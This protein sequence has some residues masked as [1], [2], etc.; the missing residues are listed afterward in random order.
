MDTRLLG[1][2][3][4][5]DNLVSDD[6]NIHLKEIQN[7]IRSFQLMKSMTIKNSKMNYKIGDDVDRRNSLVSFSHDSKYLAMCCEEDSVALWDFSLVEN[8]L[9]ILGNHDSEVSA[10]AFGENYILVSGCQN[11]IVKIWND[12]R[13][14]ED[15]CEIEAHNEEITCIAVNPKGENFVTG[16]RDMTAKIWSLEDCKEEAVLQEMGGSVMA[17][18]FTP[19]GKKLIMGSEDK[20]ITIWS[21]K[22]KAII[23]KLKGHTD[24]IANLSIT[25]TMSGTFLASN[26]QNEM[27]VWSLEK[28]KLYFDYSD[29]EN[30]ISNVSFSKKGGILALGFFTQAYIYI[31]NIENMTDKT[32]FNEFGENKERIEFS[33]D[34][35]YLVGI[36]TSNIVLLS[37]AYKEK[38]LI[39]ESQRSINKFVLYDDKIIIATENPRINI[40]G[41]YDNSIDQTINAKEKIKCLDIGVNTDMHNLLA[42]GGNLGSAVVRNLNTEKILYERKMENS[43]KALVLYDDCS[44]LAIATNQCHKIYVENFTGDEKIMHGHSDD[45]LCLCVAKNKFLFSGSQDKLVIMW[46]LETFKE[47]HVF[48]E[49]TAWVTALAYCNRSNFVA[50]GSQDS[51]IIIW[52]IDF[53]RIEFILSEHTMKITSL[54]FRDDGHYLISGSFDNSFIVWNIIERRL[55]SKIV[56]HTQNI[57]QVAMQDSS[58]I[59]ASDDRTI[60]LWGYEEDFTT[61]NDYKLFN[62]E[63]EVNFIV[64]SNCKN[65]AVIAFS[66]NY[67]F[68][69]IKRTPAIDLSNYSPDENGVYFTKHPWIVITNNSNNDVDIFDVITG[70]LIAQSSE[71]RNL[72]SP[73][74]SISKNFRTFFDSNYQNVLDYKNLVLCI[75]Q[76]TLKN[77]SLNSL[78]CTITS[79][80]FTGIHIA[81]YKG[82]HSLLQKLIKNPIIPLRTDSYGFSPLRYSI[83]RQHQLCTDALIKYVIKLSES[84][85]SQVFRSSIHALRN[86][87][88][89][90]LR[91]SSKFLKEMLDISIKSYTDV[92]RFGEPISDLPIIVTKSTSSGSFQDFMTTQ[93]GLSQKK[94][95]LLI[96]FGLIPIKNSNEDLLKS[97]V[98]YQNEDIFRS[99]FIQYIIQYNW[100]QFSLIIQLFSLFQLVS[101]LFVFIAI[102]VYSGQSWIWNS[103]VLG[104][105]FILLVIEGRQFSN[106]MQGYSEDWWN[107]ID[108]IRVILTGSYFASLF[109][110]S[111]IPDMITWLVIV[112]NAIRGLSGFRAFKTTRY[113]IRLIFLSLDKIKYFLAIFIYTILSLGFLNISTMHI[114]LNFSN[115]FVLPFAFTAGAIDTDEGL[116]VVKGITIIVAVTISIIL[117]LNMIISILGDSFDEFQLKADIFN[118]REMAGVIIEI[119]C[120]SEWFYKIEDKCEYLHICL[121]AYEDSALGWRGRVLDVRETVEE[122]RDFSKEH[123]EKMKSQTKKR[124]SKIEKNFESLEKSYKNLAGRVQRNNEDVMKKLA[125]IEE[126]VLG[127]KQED[128]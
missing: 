87:L 20:L 101:V 45:V 70:N 127:K 8:N 69:T 16:S 82:I 55:E 19:N 7:T 107:F 48:K 71:S 88:P 24:A 47:Y 30:D 109:I 17:L 102:A 14:K 49:H 90:I 29:I 120:L 84:P 123:F 116:S 128:E 15:T 89:T 117:M 26:T 5:N 41:I 95:P 51:R 65:Y 78:S 36:G 59:S 105:T 110:V 38:R 31:W 72:L 63:E 3:A 79:K 81:A 124:F 44:K 112:Y 73:A 108:I 67:M 12:A 125:R 99:E 126:A 43:I 100:N 39:W 40:K 92:V 46:D 66:A 32:I 10:L 25:E 2:Y 61:E 56:G 42:Y 75:Q 86:D 37:L 54:K 9:T 77:I 21:V 53:L 11:G 93:E 35:K 60:K 103:I 28:N 58:I 52:N 68:V 34:G 62:E 121:N 76:N 57:I 23:C 1:N 104:C 27:K 94:K 115:L 114:D 98:S 113:Y 18:V 122:F 91:N 33:P 80:R 106:D 119:K 64:F 22:E 74:S 83:D 85:D 96:K 50:S 118:Y 6:R 97:I 4:T 111:D 13:N